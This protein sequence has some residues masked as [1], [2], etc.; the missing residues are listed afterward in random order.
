MGGAVQGKAD[1]LGLS[2]LTRLS[3]LYK[4]LVAKVLLLM[5]K[6]AKAEAV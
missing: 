2:N 3:R 4:E 6:L 1:A 5:L